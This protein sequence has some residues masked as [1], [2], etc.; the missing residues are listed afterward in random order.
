MTS[1]TSTAP[2]LGD[3]LDR[4]AER[5]VEVEQ[6]GDLVAAGHL[7]HVDAR[8]G[9]EHRAALGERDHGQR[10][11]HAERAQARALE[12]V[13]GDVDLRA[14]AVADL[15]AVG[16]HR[17][18]V[19]LALADHH[20]AV[21]VDR[22]QHGVHAVDGGL[23]GGLLVAAADPARGGQRGGLGDAHELEREVAVGT[24]RRWHVRGLP[25]A[26]VDVRSLDA[27]MAPPTAIRIVPRKARYQPMPRLISLGRLA[28][29]VEMPDVDDQAERDDAD[30]RGHLAARPRELVVAEDDVEQDDRRE[31]RGEQQ[32]AQDRVGVPGRHRVAQRRRRWR[33]GLS[34][35]GEYQGRKTPKREQQAADR[36]DDLRRVRCGGRP[37]AGPTLSLCW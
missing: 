8:A 5:P 15:L 11:G 28:G 7:L 37:S 13:D 24:L 20:D 25:V 14:A 34:G 4:L 26:C 18:L 9:V 22:V 1:P 17:R 36:R 30:H 29:A 12:R 3:Q 31:R 2:A 21:H 32:P 35:L 23:V 16:E 6:V 19:L 27:R 10:V 33:C